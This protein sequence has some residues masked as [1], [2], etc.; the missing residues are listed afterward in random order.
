MS[1][2]TN[3]KYRLVFGESKVLVFEHT[4]MSNQIGCHTGA[5]AL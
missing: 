2:Y 5:A 4:R 3:A 1:F